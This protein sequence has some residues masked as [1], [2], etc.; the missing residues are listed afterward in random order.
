MKGES[1]HDVPLKK[2]EEWLR[3]KQEREKRA[4]VDRAMAKET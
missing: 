1:I 4:K 2:R 3:L